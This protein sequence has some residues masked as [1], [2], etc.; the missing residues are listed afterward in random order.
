MVILTF[1]FVQPNNSIWI[2]QMKQFHPK[3]KN[4]IP[5]LN[6]NIHNKTNYIANITKYL[7]KILSQMKQ[8]HIPN[9]TN[10]NTKFNKFYQISYYICWEI[11]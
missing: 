10:D 3:S 4:A 8:I 6:N 1:N 5:N 9:K 11:I 7:L 2:T